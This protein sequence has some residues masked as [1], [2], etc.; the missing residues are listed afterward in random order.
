MS[1]E[2]T[3]SEIVA[4]VALESNKYKKDVA[5]ILDTYYLVIREAILKGI[6]VS[7]PGVG[8]FTN[9]EVKAKEERQ[10]RDLNTGEMMTIPAHKEFNKPKFIFKPGL[11]SDMRKLTEG[12]T[13]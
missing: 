7:I 8:S 6:K 11:K 3:R 2:M 12:N 10:A 4:L 1:R 9:T 5:Y 13:L